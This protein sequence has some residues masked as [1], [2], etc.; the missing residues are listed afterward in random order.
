MQKLVI[1]MGSHLTSAVTLFTVL[2]SLGPVSMRAAQAG[3]PGSQPQTSK[4]EL[5]VPH[6]RKVKNATQ[7]IVDGRPYLM[8]AGELHNSSASSASYMEPIW[9]K[10]AGLH[11]NT[12]ISTVSWELI[13][14]VEGKFDFTSVDSQIRS[15]Q[16]HGLHLVLI[17]FATWKNASDSYAP[18]WVKKG[19][20]RFPPALGPERLWACA[21]P[22]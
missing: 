2:V 20:Q 1:C 22:P 11:L 16:Q 7:M 4:R 10:L 21:C 9:Q 15:A 19:Q 8:L 18:M 13:E 5:G 17:W 12:V 6:L 14:P 3:S